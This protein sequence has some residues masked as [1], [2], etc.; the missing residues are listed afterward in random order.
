[1][2]CVLRGLAVCLL[3]IVLPG[4]GWAQSPQAGAD[5][6][7]VVAA[8]AAA[9]NAHDLPRALDLF[10]DVG[11]ASDTAGRSYQ[12]RAAL[13]AFLAETG[14]ARPDARVATQNVH[15]VANRAVWTFTCSCAAAPMEARL[16]TNAGRITVLALQRPPAPTRMASSSIGMAEPLLLIL[17]GVAISLLLIARRK[18]HAAAPRPSQGRLLQGLREFNGHHP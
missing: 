18:P 1:V 4:V 5:P 13:M 3:A 7:G 11:S 2:R 9:I 14:L 12:G 10:D 17:A 6:A 8:Y 15:V 16:V